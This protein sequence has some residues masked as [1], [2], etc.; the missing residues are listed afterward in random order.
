MTE[1][2]DQIFKIIISNNIEENIY[3]EGKLF[4]KDRHQNKYYPN[5]VKYR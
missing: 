2:K 3:Y 5:I 4:N 1:V